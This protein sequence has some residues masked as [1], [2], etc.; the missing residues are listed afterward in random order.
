LAA[1]SSTGQV[2]SSFRKAFTDFLQ[3]TSIETQEFEQYWTS[4][5]RLQTYGANTSTYFASTYTNLVTYN[6]Y[7]NFGAP[8]IAD[9]AAQNEERV[10]FINPTPLVRWSYGRDNVT[11][12]MYAEAE[13][14][15]QIYADFIQGSVLQPDGERCSRAI[16]VVPN[17][18]GTTS[19]RVRLL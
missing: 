3:P 18:L 8:W 10:P 11:A 16:Y 6:Q 13:R 5:G 7:N 4:S 1:N 17:S 2:F 9:Y 12:A 15:K 19:Y 14:R